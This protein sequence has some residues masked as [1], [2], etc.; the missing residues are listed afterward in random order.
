[1]AK[2][3]YISFE[4]SGQLRNLRRQR[5]ATFAEMTN[6]GMPIPQGFTVTTEAAQTTTNSGKQITKEIQD[7]IFEALIHSSRA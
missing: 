3:V 7:Q 6:L 1:M 4:E 2:W 5:V